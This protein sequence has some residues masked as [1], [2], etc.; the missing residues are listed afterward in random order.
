MSRFDRRLKGNSGG[1]SSPRPGVSTC[2]IRSNSNT[3]MLSGF[4][5]VVEKDDNNNSRQ[6]KN[7]LIKE[8][9]S[10]TYENNVNDKVN[11]TIRINDTLKIAI[12]QTTDSKL[13]QLL[14]HELRLNTLEMNLD[15]LT[16]LKCEEIS[17]EQEKNEEELS[18]E[19]MKKSVLELKKYDRN[20]RNENEF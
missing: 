9:S 15:C 7:H 17:K 13:K 5:S 18:L 2:K 20:R 6:E 12:S 11:N 4:I 14:I 19:E 8:I 1:R 16:D 10:K 3:K